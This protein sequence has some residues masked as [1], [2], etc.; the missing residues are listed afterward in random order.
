V[1]FDLANSPCTVDVP[2]VRNLPQDQAVDL[3]KARAIAER[4]IVI[5]T[6]AVTEPSQDGIVLDQDIEGTNAKPF[7]VTLTVGALDQSIAPTEPPTP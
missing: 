3:L 2:N 7:K 5:V 6:Q 1:R 4:N